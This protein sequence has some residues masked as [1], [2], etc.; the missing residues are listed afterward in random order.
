MLVAVR[1]RTREIGIRKA[2]GARRQDLSRQFLVE[3]VTVSLAGGALGALIGVL[4]AGIVGRAVNVQAVPTWQGVGLAFASSALVG[5]VA[6]WW[7]ARQAAQL[8]PVVALRYE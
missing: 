4:A 2:I 3:A 6:G 5:A 8:D 1:E 7:P